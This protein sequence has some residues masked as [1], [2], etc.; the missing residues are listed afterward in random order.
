MGFE[1]LAEVVRNGVADGV[2]H[3]ADALE[4]IAQEV[5]GPG[6]AELFE[7]V[8]E[9]HARG[10]A[11]QVGEIRGVHVHSDC[12]VGELHGAGVMFVNVIQHLPNNLLVVA[13]AW[14]QVADCRLLGQAGRVPYSEIRGTRFIIG[15]PRF[16]CRLQIVDD[17]PCQPHCPNEGSLADRGSRR[18]L[19]HRERY[20]MP[21]QDL[22]P[23]AVVAGTAKAGKTLLRPL[24][25][26]PLR[27]AFSQARV[28]SLREL[29]RWVLA[30][31]GTEYGRHVACCVQSA[32]GKWGGLGETTGLRIS[33]RLVPPGVKDAAP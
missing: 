31:S 22:D 4:R 27:P 20:R 7:I 28:A 5:L 15:S 32:T 26:P 33:R 1:D 8:V 9:G 11:K 18:G 16:K 3:F 14:L 25:V 29:A 19:L 12:Q 17:E 2:G 13:V 21:V 30:R 6:K 10:G 24:A 23:G